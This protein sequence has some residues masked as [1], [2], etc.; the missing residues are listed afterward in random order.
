MVKLFIN[1]AD[2]NPKRTTVYEMAGSG[3]K[4]LEISTLQ[5]TAT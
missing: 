5:L 4:P 1:Q 2:K 3:L